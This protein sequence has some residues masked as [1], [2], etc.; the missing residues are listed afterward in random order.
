MNV[1]IVDDFVYS[2]IKKFSDV[3]LL[4][5]LLVILLMVGLMILLII[6]GEKKLWVVESVFFLIVG[7]VFGLNSGVM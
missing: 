7:K 2:E 4:W 1:E 5:V 6:L 3:I